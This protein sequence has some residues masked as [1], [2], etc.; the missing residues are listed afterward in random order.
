MKRRPRGDIE[1]TGGWVNWPLGSVAISKWVRID[2]GL[3]QHETWPSCRLYLDFMRNPVRHGALKGTS[4]RRRFTL[5]GEA[6]NDLASILWRGFR[7]AKGELRV[8]DL[9]NALEQLRALDVAGVVDPGGPEHE[10]IS[11]R[12]ERLKALVVTRRGQNEN[13]SS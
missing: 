9:D 4:L 12:V 1:P 6:A 13:E 10:T 8:V 5:R 2:V 3:C 7:I 11:E